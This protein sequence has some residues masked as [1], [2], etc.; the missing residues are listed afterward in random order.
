MI[1]MI[2]FHQTYLWANLLLI[3]VGYPK[4]FL[5]ISKLLR[6]E[7]DDLKNSECFMSHFD[8]YVVEKKYSFE[9]ID[10]I[11]EYILIG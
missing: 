3:Y 6:Y 7:S 1:V 2:Y 5:K 8:I 11:E 9:S 10:V 4:D